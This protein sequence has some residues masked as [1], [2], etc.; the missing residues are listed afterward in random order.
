MSQEGVFRKNGNIRELNELCDAIDRDPKDLS[1]L[2][3]SPIQ[4]AALLKRFLREL[5]EPLLTFKLYD[6]LLASTSKISL[7]YDMGRRL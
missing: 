1:Y 3:E 5:P 7:F 2:N 6:L 4:L